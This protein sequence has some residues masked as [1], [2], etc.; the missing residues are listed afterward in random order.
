[1]DNTELEM[2]RTIAAAERARALIEDPLLVEAFQRVHDHC[3]SA[4]L[5]SPADAPELRE[6]LW[7][8]IQALAE[9]RLELTRALDDGV[10]AQAQLTELRTGSTN[11]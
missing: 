3:L 2:R 11:L 6:K 5:N 1:M 4:W 8:H 7:H 10:M 9:V